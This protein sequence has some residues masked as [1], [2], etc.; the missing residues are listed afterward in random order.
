MNIEQ[1]EYSKAHFPLPLEFTT[2]HIKKN[3]VVDR[4][5][6]LDQE[7]AFERRIQDLSFSVW[8]CRFAK[9]LYGWL[10]ISHSTMTRK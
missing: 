7:T 1:F 6:W 5:S 8:L 3:Y 4:A 2:T 9:S 10:N